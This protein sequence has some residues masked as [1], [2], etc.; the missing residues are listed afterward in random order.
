MD[1]AVTIDARRSEDSVGRSVLWHVEH[2]VR[3][4]ARF[5]RAL[6]VEIDRIPEYQEDAERLRQGLYRR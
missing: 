2:V 5:L 6:A 3:N 4:G 1:S